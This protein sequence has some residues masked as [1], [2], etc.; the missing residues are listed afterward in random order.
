MWTQPPDKAAEQNEVNG[1]KMGGRDD[2]GYCSVTTLN[3]R[4]IGDHANSL[5]VRHMAKIST[6][7]DLTTIDRSSQ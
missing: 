2:E 4:T 7:F 5:T 3:K 6:G 1:N